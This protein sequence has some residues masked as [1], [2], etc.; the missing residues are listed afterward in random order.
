MNQLIDDLLAYSRLE[1][2]E[3]K[4]DRVE[5]APMIHSLVEEKRRE[6]AERPIDFVVDV[7]GATVLAD[8]SGLTQQ[9]SRATD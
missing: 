9:C 3:L 6:A 7:N 4:T 1:R 8:A 5:L 2:R